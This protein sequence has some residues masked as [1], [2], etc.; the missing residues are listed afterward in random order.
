LSKPRPDY[1]R[2]RLE[3]RRWI[4]LNGEWEFGAGEHPR[5]ERRIT[6]PFCPQA[7]LSG[8][9]ERAPGDLLWYRRRFAAAVADRLLLHFGAVDYRAQVF[10]NGVE[11][12][13][14]EGGHTPF[15]ADLS[16][17]AEGP[18]NE[19]V[20]RVE[21]D[22]HDPTL[23]R[24]KQS[25][26]DVSESIFY[27]P[28]CGIWQ[29]VW[30]E[31]VSADAVRELRVRP[32][33]AAAAVELEVQ[34]GGS[35]EV[36][37]L[38]EGVVAGR[39]A[40]PP[41]TYRLELEPV[42]AWSPESPRLY[43]LEI[44][45]RDADGKPVD[46][47]RSYFGLRTVEAR[48]GYFWL[49][50]EPYVQRLVLDQGYFPGGLLTAPTDADLRRDIELAK[51]MGFNG[52][53]KHQKIEDPRWLY[54]ADRLG[55]LVWAEMPGFHRHSEEAERRLRTEWEAAVRRDRDHPSI[56]AWVP[57]NEGFGL[58]EADDAVRTRLLVE[59]YELTHR[60]DGTRPVVSNDGW[61]HAQTDVC[62]LHDYDGAE[63]LARRYR[64]LA[65]TLDPGGRPLPPYLPGCKHAAEPVIVSEF[66]GI[67]L[68]GAGG[69]AYGEVGGPDELLAAYLAQV[70]AL[71]GP[72]PVEGFCYT[73]LT[74]VEQ[75]RNGLLSFDRRPK[76][77]PGL[78][79]PAT[80]TGKQRV[81]KT[82][83]GESIC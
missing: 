77:E 8:I 15:T 68:A 50:G 60:L 58:Q 30:L 55:F 66:G 83:S 34:A 19:L 67:R 27:T 54:W 18:E 46:E 37:A 41:G 42:A 73:Q 36:T 1:P 17:V 65:A 40:G 24:G 3:R 29:T 64:T 14:H 39:F 48:D 44:V 74:D 61:Q 5:F 6:V 75:E 59:L 21:D 26:T 45:V 79:R 47:V 7:G 12:A 10:V 20:V 57:M 82:G 16:G 56:V 38:L 69:W 70:E 51:A 80:E 33:L 81:L 32:D 13:R 35:I 63:Q 43:D 49:N 9:G 11:V 71:M 2:P 25:S 78:L 22:L 76:L 23:P 4:N 72:G 31:P 28:T 52:A 53:R 62:T